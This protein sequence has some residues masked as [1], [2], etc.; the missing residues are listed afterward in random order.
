M[1]SWHSMRWDTEHSVWAELYEEKPTMAS[2]CLRTRW[3]VGLTLP[4]KMWLIISNSR[5][6][7]YNPLMY[8]FFFHF[9]FFSLINPSFFHLM[10]SCHLLYKHWPKLSLPLAPLHILTKKQDIHVPSIH[11]ISLFGI[12]QNSTLYI[13]SDLV[14]DLFFNYFHRDKINT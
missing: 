6:G 5:F 8:V 4:C 7:L 10:N 12:G 9:I 14:I 11:H 3:A 1:I 13:F 2:W